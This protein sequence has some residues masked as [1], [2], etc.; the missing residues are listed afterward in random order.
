MTPRGNTRRGIARLCAVVM[1][2]AAPAAGRA[3]PWPTPRS[4]HY[5][6]VSLDHQAGGH[7]DVEINFAVE[8]R[9]PAGAARAPATARTRKTSTSTSRPGFIGNPHATPQCSIADFSA[10]HLPDRLA[11][12]HRQRDDHRRRRSRFNAA[13]YNL[14]P[15]PDDAGLIGFKIILFDAPQFTVLSARTDSDYGLDAT[16]TS[17]YHGPL[18]SRLSSR[19]SGGFPPTPCH[20]PLRLDPRFNAERYRATATTSANFCDANGAAEHH[21]SRAPI[22]K[23]CGSAGQFR[24]R[25]RTAR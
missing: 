16:A 14:I 19:S 24:R 18:R 9:L 4:P 17:I 8:N 20:D 10:G 13:V 22:V 21:G 25:R 15:P 1:A 5:S 2:L 23:P 3:R 6:A 12:R 11:G 7:P